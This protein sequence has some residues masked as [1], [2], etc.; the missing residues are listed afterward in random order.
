MIHTGNSWNKRDLAPSLLEGQ[1]FLISK[2]EHTLTEIV[3]QLRSKF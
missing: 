2:L 3:E 1:Y